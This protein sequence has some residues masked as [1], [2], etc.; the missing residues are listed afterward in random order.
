MKVAGCN[1][2]KKR[3]GFCPMLDS[4]EVV[5]SSLIFLDRVYELFTPFPKPCFELHFRFTAEIMATIKVKHPSFT[6]TQLVGVVSLSTRP[7]YKILD[8]LLAFTLI[9]F[10]DTTQ[11]KRWTYIRNVILK[12]KTLGFCCRPMSS[13][14]CKFMNFKARNI[15]WHKYG[16]Y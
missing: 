13:A 8:R 15:T 4:L 6:P 3:G 16:K 10:C 1:N 7:F 11:F 2:S 5:S 9:S 14:R 12:L